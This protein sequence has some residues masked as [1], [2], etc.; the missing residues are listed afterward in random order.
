MYESFS[1]YPSLLTLDIIIVFNLTFLLC[2]EI[3]LIVVWIFTSS[4]LTTLS[5][6]YWLFVYVPLGR[7]CPNFLPIF[8]ML[9]VFWLL[10]GRSLLYILVISPLAAIWLGILSHIA[11]LFIA[12]QAII[13]GNHCFRH[14]FF[15]EPYKGRILGRGLEA[16]QLA[17]TSV[18]CF[19]FSSRK[20]FFLSQ[21]SLAS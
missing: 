7:A 12:T 8:I 13:L 18:L 16:R 6:T 9:F 20:F 17:R 21:K 5:S 4:R 14:S 11:F 3:Y 19:L 1:C 15:I 10:S 2:V